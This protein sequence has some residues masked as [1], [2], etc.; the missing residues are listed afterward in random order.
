MNKVG[1]FEI[2]VPARN[3]LRVDFNLECQQRTG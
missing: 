3:N 1:Y 2:C